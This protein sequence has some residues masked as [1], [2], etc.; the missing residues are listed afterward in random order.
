MRERREVLT[1]T[2]IPLKTATL[3][4]L[5]SDLYFGTEIGYLCLTVRLVASSETWEEREKDRHYRDLRRLDI[6]YRY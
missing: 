1:P 2:K 6:N 5:T 4:R 3:V